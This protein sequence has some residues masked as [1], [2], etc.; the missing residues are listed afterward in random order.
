MKNEFIERIVEE[1][2]VTDSVV[3]RIAIA[4]DTK[5]PE[6]VR[7]YENF[8]TLG[9]I[10]MRVKGDAPV[11]ERVEFATAHGFTKMPMP[12]VSDM[13]GARKPSTYSACEIAAIIVDYYDP[14]RSHE[15]FR[16]FIMRHKISASAFSSWM[17][18]ITFTGAI[19]G[20]R[21]Y[22][23][24]NKKYSASDI[25]RAHKLYTRSIHKFNKELADNKKYLGNGTMLDAKARVHAGKILY[26][27]LKRLAGGVTA[28]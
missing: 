12:K 1:G 17:R 18:E 26:E 15:R 21:V 20:V 6:A 23:L 14:S 16:R 10:D 4:T 8:K 19:R 3:K 7:A 27:N 2:R 13:T 25:L 22:P 11:G 24:K 5:L 9:V 28:E